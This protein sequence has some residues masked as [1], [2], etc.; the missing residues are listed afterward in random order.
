MELDS[1]DEEMDEDS[2]DKNKSDSDE[3]SGAEGD[4]SAEDSEDADKSKGNAGWA[5]A[6]AKILRTNKPK[7]KKTIVLSKA[8]KLNEIVSK[9]K[10]EVVPFEIEQQNGE[11]N[12]EKKASESSEVTSQQKKN[13]KKDSLG[14]RIK[15]WEKTDREH[16]RHLKKIATA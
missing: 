3:N 6:M 12:Q 15:P 16:E 11:A 7:R 2:D 9:P 10:E 14:I 4:E 13:K 1:P 5:D 8:K